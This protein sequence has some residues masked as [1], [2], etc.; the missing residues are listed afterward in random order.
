MASFHTRDNQTAIATGTTGTHRYHT[1]PVGLMFM[2]T[3]TPYM[4]HKQPSVETRSC[5]LFA[6]EPYED[7]GSVTQSGSGPLQIRDPPAMEDR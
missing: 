6:S 5:R 1:T 2:Q 4:P 7:R 3:R